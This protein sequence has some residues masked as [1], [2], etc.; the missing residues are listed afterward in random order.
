MLRGDGAGRIPRPDA[1]VLGEMECRV[2]GLRREGAD[3]KRDILGARRS[4]RDIRRSGSDDRDG[5][6]CRRVHG[7]NLIRTVERSVGGLQMN[8]TSCSDAGG[9]E[10]RPSRGQSRAAQHGTG[11]GGQHLGGQMQFAEEGRLAF[12]NINIV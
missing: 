4:D 2:G 6:L 7:H 11:P 9:C 5:Q 3:S 12:Q 10:V 1:K 8:D